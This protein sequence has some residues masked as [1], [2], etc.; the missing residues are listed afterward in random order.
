MIST[1][2]WVAKFA[3]ARVENRVYFLVFF[4]A[5]AVDIACFQKWHSSLLRIQV[6]PC[7]ETRD[8]CSNSGYFQS[9]VVT[10]DLDNDRRG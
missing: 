6:R 1:E 5:R 7:K 8:F 3:P 10:A 4:L 2:L 9:H